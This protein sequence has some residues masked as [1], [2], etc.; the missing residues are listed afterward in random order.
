MVSQRMI[1]AEAKSDSSA[2]VRAQRLA[3]T[4]QVRGA[5]DRCASAPTGTARRCVSFQYGGIDMMQTF[6]KIK[7][8]DIH[9]LTII[10]LCLWAA[11]KSVECME[12]PKATPAD[13]A[14][15][16]YKYY[17]NIVISYFD[18]RYLPPPCMTTTFELER[19]SIH[20][21]NPIVVH[22]FQRLFSISYSFYKYR[23]D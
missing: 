10:M 4:T 1:T 2:L 11:D 7:S 14:G 19:E 20:L 15:G 9:W 13:T 8:F 23:I 22:I 18:P 16:V 21:W 12:Q 6:L 17:L 3:P 5:A